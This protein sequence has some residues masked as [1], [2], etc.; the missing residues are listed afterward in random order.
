MQPNQFQIKVVLLG[1]SGVGKSSIVVRYIEDRFYE[2]LEATIGASFLSKTIELQNKV[3]KFN[4]WDTAGQE[5]YHALS[6]MYYSDSQAAILVYDIT[7]RRSYDAMKQWYR[8]LKEFGP[9]SLMIAVAG[10]KEDLVENE[11]VDMN[12]AREFAASIGAIYK[13]TSAKTRYGIDQI[14]RE[15]ATKGKYTESRNSINLSKKIPEKGNS[16]RGCC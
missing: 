8:E 14:F 10:N 7:N 15:I 5:R 13:K 16:R 1:D 3:V 9:R 6:K 12:E 4:I 2:D 11:E